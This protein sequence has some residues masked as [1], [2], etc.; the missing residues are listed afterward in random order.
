MT[1]DGTQ[2]ELEFYQLSLDLWLGF[3]GTAASR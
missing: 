1:G 3:T 2:V